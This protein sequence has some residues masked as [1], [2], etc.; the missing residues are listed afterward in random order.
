MTSRVALEGRGYQGFCDNSTK[1]LLIKSVTMGACQELWKTR[2]VIYGRH[3]N[4]EVKHQLNV[5]SYFY[6][7]A[8]M[9]TQQFCL[10]FFSNSSSSSS[11]I[12]S[13]KFQTMALLKLSCLCLTLWSKWRHTVCSTDL[14]RCKRA[15]YLETI[16]TTVESS[17]IFWDSLGSSEN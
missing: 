5:I 8:M 12:N 10:L 7:P 17:F 1:A 13:F 4:T 9:A 2:D 15:N 11:S 6:I 14:D 16:L 3:L